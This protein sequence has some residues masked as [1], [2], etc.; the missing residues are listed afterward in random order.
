MAYRLSRSL[1]YSFLAGLLFSSVSP[2]SLLINAI[3]VDAAGLWNPR[4]LQVLVR[5]GEGG[6]VLA[7]V[8]LPLAI[9]LLDVALSRNKPHWHFLAALAMAAAALSNW[10]GAFALAS[11]ILSY[12]LC[13]RP[14]W[15]AW[16]TAAG[17]AM[18]A[19]LLAA[20]W[21]PPS[22]IAAVRANSQMVE[23][24][25]PMVE[26]WKFWVPFLAA[27][28]VVFWFL[29]SR[30]APPVLQ[31]SALFFWF[32]GGIT[33]T[34][35]WGNVYLLPQPHRYQLELE[36]TGVLLL[37]FS[38]KWLLGRIPGQTFLQA[39][40]VVLLVL[41]CARGLVRY[42][43]SAHGLDQPVDIHTTVEYRMAEWLDNHVRND[44]VLMPGS[45]SQWLNAFT[46]TPQ[47]GGVFDQ[48]ITNPVVPDALF[49]IFS[50]M[51]A[52]TRAGQ[53]SVMWLKA[54]GVR[55]V[56][57][58]GGASMGPFHD[59][60]KFDGLLPEMWR[61]GDDVIY[62]VPQ[63]WPSLAHVVLPVD[64]V[65][66]RPET[67]LDTEP[68]QPYLRALDDPSRAPAA[69][70]WKT[71]QEAEVIADLTRGEQLSIS[72]NHHPG[73]HASV[74]G[75]ARPVRKD[76]IGLMVVDP[77]CEG[78][79]TV[80]LRFDGGLEMRVARALAA[81]ALSAGVLIV[82]GAAFRRILARHAFK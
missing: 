29:N 52:G 61:S 31:F 71:A 73:W 27:A 28:A 75:A 80:L 3:R 82:L 17:L 2:A 56:G 48:G 7:L 50:G 40:I 57:V 77:N 30:S 55:A 42:N 76:G 49:Q 78:R 36:L 14:E 69:F 23:G 32:M 74:G 81:L 45:V 34:W 53:V 68:L 70:Q 20:P 79:C 38:V 44:R 1:L 15:R 58:S 33:L 60:H 62:Q 51:N 47:L 37:A 12:L 19:Y 64:L 54:F 25:W 6:H 18:Y 26:A 4:R 67:A 22:T 65:P 35:Y 21:I 11:A 24:S 9:L 46:D 43:K 39:A 72:I 13:Y 63:H 5:Y 10:L 41:I 59:P 66:R 8:L 16:I